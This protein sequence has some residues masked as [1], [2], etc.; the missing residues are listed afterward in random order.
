MVGWGSAVLS[1]VWD[2]KALGASFTDFLS[3]SASLLKDRTESFWGSFFF[4]P[5]LFQDEAESGWILLSSSKSPLQFVGLKF[6]PKWLPLESQLPAVHGLM[7][8][9]QAVMS[10]RALWPWWRASEKQRRV[11]LVPVWDGC[12]VA[13]CGVRSFYMHCT[14]VDGWGRLYLYAG[15]GNTEAPCTPPPSTQTQPIRRQQGG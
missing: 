9:Q 1:Y 8:S 12:P 14:D 15:T 4:H 7:F 10:L 11:E 3:I 5:S 13:C 2:R 6:R